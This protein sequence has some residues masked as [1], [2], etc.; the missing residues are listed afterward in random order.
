MAT[1]SYTDDSCTLWGSEMRLVGRHL[2]FLATIPVIK[3]EGTTSNRIFIG[4]LQHVIDI[5]LLWNVFPDVL[6]KNENLCEEEYGELKKIHIEARKIIN[7]LEIEKKHW[8]E[9][10]KIIL[11]E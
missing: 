9:I 8:R 11:N 2:Q 4:K 1:V 5:D 10:T 6:W 3:L 7:E